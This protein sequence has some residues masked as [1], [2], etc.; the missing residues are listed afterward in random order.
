MLSPTLRISFATGTG[1]RGMERT[2]ELCPVHCA[3]LGNGRGKK[4]GR[5][6]IRHLTS[7]DAAVHL[8]LVLL[9]LA[10]PL[11]IDRAQM[12]YHFCG[13]LRCRASFPHSVGAVLQGC[14]LAPFGCRCVNSNFF[15]K[16]PQCQLR[17]SMQ[18]QRATSSRPSL[19][20]GTFS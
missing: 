15:S 19:N 6:K 1:R 18:D 11:E 2:A 5:G 3:Q 7:L 13:V 12:F 4:E 20:K 9:Q 16:S 14:W 10:A 8:S 17:G